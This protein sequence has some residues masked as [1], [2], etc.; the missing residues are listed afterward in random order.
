M[1]KYAWTAK[2]VPGMKDEYKRRH[3]EIWQS[4]KD[5]LNEAGIVNYTIWLTGDVLFGYYECTEGIAHAARVQAQSR[6]REEWDKYMKDVLIMEKD[7]VT[8]A[9]P[10]LECVFSFN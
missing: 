9:Q 1:E 4:M 3:D 7:P 10:K 5:M 6:I 8:G 2:I